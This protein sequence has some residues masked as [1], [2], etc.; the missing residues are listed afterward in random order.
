[1]SISV[2]VRYFAVV[3]ER[4]GKEL[5][6]IALEEGATVS[7]AMELLA[8]RYPALAALGNVVRAAVNQ[9][10]SPGSHILGD[11]DELALIPPVAGGA[12]ERAPHARVIAEPLSLD[13][14]IAAVH[15]TF[16]G[17]VAT[18]AG[19]VREQTH[20]RQVI[21]LE[22]EAYVEMAERV[23]SRLCTEIETEI[24]GVRVAV[25]HRV[26]T[27][28]LGELA[29]VV[30]AAS[31]HRAEAFTAARALIDRLKQTAPIWKKEVFADGAEWVQCCP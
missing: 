2:T 27:L 23:L 18:F 13:R 1:M 28:A 30:A 4:L 21:Q 26:G 16:A 19:A 12:D 11:G 8:A 10:M 31:P 7:D 25:E 9:E 15:G 20:G 17:A 5:E 6:T 29:V 22:Y 3:R 24:E 14:V